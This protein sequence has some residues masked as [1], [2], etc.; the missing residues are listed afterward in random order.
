MI[1]SDDDDDGDLDQP[2]SKKGKPTSKKGVEKRLRELEKVCLEL[3]T[4]NRNLRAEVKK[5]KAYYSR[6]TKVD[7]MNMFD[8][9][10][11]EANLAS[12]ISN[13]S[14]DYLFT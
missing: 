4:E 7:M 10:G 14:K 6:T 5:S 13:F 9:N 11:E 8:C 3:R 2:A 12:M 1:S